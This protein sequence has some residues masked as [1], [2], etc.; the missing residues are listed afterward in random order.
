MCGAHVPLLKFHGYQ[1][2]IVHFEAEIVSQAG[3]LGNPRGTVETWCTRMWGLCGDL[4][5][6]FFRHRRFARSTRSAGA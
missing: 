6:M 1:Q 2:K 5:D 3:T 4:Q